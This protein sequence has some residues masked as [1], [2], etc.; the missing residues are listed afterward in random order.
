M[1]AA[2]LMAPEAPLPSETSETPDT[3]PA[4]DGSGLLIVD[5]SNPVLPPHI[6]DHPFTIFPDGRVFEGTY[7]QVKHLAAAG[8]APDFDLDRKIRETARATKEARIRE[9]ME[10][11][12]GGVAVSFDGSA[13][14]RVVVGRPEA[15][16]DAKEGPSLDFVTPPTAEPVEEP[17]DPGPEFIAQ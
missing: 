17:I 3:M 2:V 7:E 4:E 5:P 14:P 8:D 9:A 12:T 15:D 11:A 1:H 10:A 16:P 6:G 13:P